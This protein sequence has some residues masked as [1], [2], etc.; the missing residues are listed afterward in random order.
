MKEA[1]L[2]VLFSSALGFVAAEDPV[3]ICGLDGFNLNDLYL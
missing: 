3:G 1:L 2:C